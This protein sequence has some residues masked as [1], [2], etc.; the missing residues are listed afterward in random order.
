MKRFIPVLQDVPC[1]S[2]ERKSHSRQECYDWWI[3]VFKERG[4]AFFLPIQQIFV[5]A[6][7]VSTCMNFLLNKSACKQI[8]QIRISYQ[9]KFSILSFLSFHCCFSRP[10]SR[11]VTTPSVMM[12]IHSQNHSHLSRRGGS[13]TAMTGQMPLATSRLALE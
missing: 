6:C 2:Y 7:F 1:G 10:I 8:H 5:C 4:S 9:I 3:S 12:R 11:S 13:V